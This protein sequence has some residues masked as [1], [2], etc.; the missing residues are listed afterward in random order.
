[1]KAF[2]LNFFERRL[3]KEFRRLKNDDLHNDTKIIPLFL[4]FFLLSVAIQAV[5]NHSMNGFYM[6]IGVIILTILTYLLRKILK[7]YSQILLVIIIAGWNLARFYII[8]EDYDQINK[9]DLFYRGCDFA[10]MEIMLISRF[11]ELK[12]KAIC[13]IIIYAMKLTSLSLLEMKFVHPMI[14]ARNICIDLFTIFVFFSNEKKERNVFQKFF[15]FRE[16]L[17]KFKEL[18]A[19]YLPQ[20]ITVLHTSTYK[21]LFSNKA[22][23]ELFEHT[24]E[25][26]KSPYITGAL[27]SS[28]SEGE[29]STKSR[30]EL[31]RVEKNTVRELGA[32]DLE[33]DLAD[34]FLNFQDLL[35][36]VDKSGILS[37]KALSLSA[38]YN[39][40]ETRK[41]FHVVLKK[42]RWD[43][44]DAIAIFL[45]DITYQ[46]KLLEMKLADEN[47]DQVIATV[48]HELRT[49]LNGIIGILALAEEKVEDPEVIDYMN[50]CKDN[51]NLL[52]SLVNSILDLQQIR[53]GKLA[54]HPAEIDLYKILKNIT[55]LFY[56]QCQQKRITLKLDIDSS[57]PEHIFTDENRLKQI[58]INLIGN[59]LKFTMK[60]GITVKVYQDPADQDAIEIK[61]I[62]TGIGIRKDDLCKLF[63][64]FGRLKD[65]ENVNKQGVGLGLI[66]SSALARLLSGKPEDDQ[67]IEVASEYGKGSTF[68]FTVL[69]DLRNS[70]EEL[71]VNLA[72]TSK[73][74]S[75]FRKKSKKLFDLSESNFTTYGDHDES[76]IPNQI[77]SKMTTYNFIKSLHGRHLDPPK[78]S[79]S[80]NNSPIKIDK[81]MSL[82]E[83]YSDGSIASKY[84]QPT[85][86]QPCAGVYDTPKSNFGKKYDSLIL[87]KNRIDYEAQV[88]APNPKGCILVVDDNPFNL[89]VAENHVKQAGF[90]LL[91]AK[92]GKEAIE[93]SRVASRDEQPF[94]AILMDCQ[95]PIMDGFETTRVLKKMMEDGEISEMPIIALTA[96]NGEKEINAC[97]ESG[98]TDYLAKP[99]TAAS[100][101]KML[102]KLDI[103]P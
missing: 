32:L 1:M 54:L 13:L 36:E 77:D 87:Q 49:P 42:V 44:E 59:A 100:L 20:S 7:K 28:R 50:L 61:V 97:F 30:L 52:L 22:F 79:S 75:L 70:G 81:L 86:K 85:K 96:N 94:K 2:R 73:S 69:T 5:I 72:S 78:H 34:R 46:E 66:I 31:L 9:V 55:K 10:S 35:E 11:A 68:G 3:E 29:T 4:L 101:K 18:L 91:M 8:P 99:L 27:F 21:P 60:G 19:N 40:F 33:P 38:S 51:A 45:S 58:L 47:K 43:H 90:A 93:M 80:K 92:S 98:M 41:V 57:A 84:Y 95:M 63:Q 15:E 83:L 6:T 39:Y 48:S 62:D 88:E 56:F 65:G 89:L 26:L 82:E 17:T 102:T 37:R 23:F 16:D 24:E 71:D 53:Q 64:K 12:W 14:I 67:G 25:E 74:R 76:L 103:T